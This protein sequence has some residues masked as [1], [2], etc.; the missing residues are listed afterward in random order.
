MKRVIIP[1]TVLLCILV[2][3]GCR[4]TLP[5][6]EL[7]ADGW[8]TGSLEEAGI[9]E[10]TLVRLVARIENGK[11]PNIH[12]ILIVKE[13]KL[14][15]EKYFE[16][17]RFAYDRELTFCFSQLSPNVVCTDFENTVQLGLEC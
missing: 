9:Q 17:H 14:V 13:G 7:M 1:I 15:L 11:I 8:L 5:V 10:K 2:V 6:P 12:G 4:S 16:G 3:E